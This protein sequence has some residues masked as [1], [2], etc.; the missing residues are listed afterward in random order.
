MNIIIPLAGE[1][2]RLRPLSYSTP[3]PLFPI[4]GRTILER[5]LLQIVRLSSGRTV[6]ALGFVVSP[7]QK[8][9]G[10]VIGELAY[11][12]KKV[13]GMEPCFFVQE[14]AEGTAHAIWCARELLNDE[15]VLIA[16]ADTIFIP[17]TYSMERDCGHLWTYHVEDP[18]SYGVVLTDS[19]GYITKL[20]EKPPTP[21]SHLAIIG[22]YHL[23]EGRSLLQKIEYLL[24]NN[25]REKGEFQITSALQL[26]VDSGIRIKSA[27]VKVWLDCGRPEEMLTAARRLLEMEAPPNNSIIEECAVIKNSIIHHP[28]Y[29]GREAIIENSVIGPY[30]CVEARARIVSSSIG[31][32]IILKDACIEEAELTLSVVGNF[33]IIKGIRGAVIVADYSKVVGRE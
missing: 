25:I 12:A 13:L 17:E 20:V 27:P 1:A 21:V 8:S 23:P 6:G 24:A 19:N 22:I 33:A 14:T 11:T 16:F 30:T 9:K 29:I 18:S 7:V 26:L 15:E 3:K 5:I 31:Q 28:C 4:A 2:K 10:E 32:S